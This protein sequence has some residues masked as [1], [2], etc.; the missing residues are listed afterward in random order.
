MWTYRYKHWA[1]IFLKT[2]AQIMLCVCWYRYY[3]CKGHKKWRNYFC[4]ITLKINTMHYICIYR[5]TKITF[6]CNQV[7]KLWFLLL[8][9]TALQLVLIEH[10]LIL[11]FVCSQKFDIISKN[12]VSSLPSALTLIH[13]CPL[14]YP[15]KSHAGI[16][17][18]RVSCKWEGLRVWQT[19]Q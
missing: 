14:T 15:Q 12:F 9:L 7:Q 18:L 19:V 8:S 11:L 5:I 2:F 16:Y 6:F 1:W 10:L 17:V 4:M 3:V 13:L